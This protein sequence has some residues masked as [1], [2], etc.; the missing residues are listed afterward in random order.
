MTKH[1]NVWIWWQVKDSVWTRQSEWCVCFLVLNV[2]YMR[3]CRGLP[4]VHRIALDIRISHSNRT[5]KIC[6]VT[7]AGRHIFS[8]FS[9]AIA[10]GNGELPLPDQKHEVNSK[11]F[12]DVVFWNHFK[13][14]NQ[15]PVNFSL[16]LLLLSFWKSFCKVKSIRLIDR[17]CRTNTKN[18]HPIK[19]LRKHCFAYY[20][21]QWKLLTK[22]ATKDARVTF[23]CILNIEVDVG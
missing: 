22:P 13:A 8:Y 16:S 17:P 3:N 6:N 4:G 7:V 2:A 23:K 14:A 5:E 18:L 12:S 19:I 15:K 9:F 10:Y 20:I 11:H 1:S 21:K